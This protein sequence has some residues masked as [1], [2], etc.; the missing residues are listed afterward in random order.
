MKSCSL[1]IPQSDEC[2]VSLYLQAKIQAEGEEFQVSLS[3]KHLSA[4]E[5]VTVMC[6]L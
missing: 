1:S 3:W 5:A 6:Y 2:Q 4:F